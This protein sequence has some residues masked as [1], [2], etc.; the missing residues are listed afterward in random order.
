MSSETP[1]DWF[2]GKALGLG[3]EYFDRIGSLSPTD[4]AEMAYEIADAMLVARTK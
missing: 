2:A 1:R 3:G 4:I